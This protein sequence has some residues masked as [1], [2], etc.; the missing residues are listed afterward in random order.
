MPGAGRRRDDLPGDCGPGGLRPRA[1]P[2]D[3]GLRRLLL[4]WWGLAFLNCF[5]LSASCL[6]AFL[7]GEVEEGLGWR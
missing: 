6:V 4:H 7:L 1:Q 2:R 3:P 5:H